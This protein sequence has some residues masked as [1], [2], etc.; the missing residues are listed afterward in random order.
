M[1]GGVSWE[2]VR[3]P[4]EQPLTVAGCSLGQRS[5]AVASLLPA[6]PGEAAPGA[7][8]I[9][10]EGKL[11]PGDFPGRRRLSLCVPTCLS[12]AAVP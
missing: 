2:G 6:P 10:R 5:A 11:R 12:P 1:G 8:A 7:P 9:P 4:W 3:F